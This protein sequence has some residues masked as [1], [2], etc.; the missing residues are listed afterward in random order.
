MTA[1]KST[2]AKRPRKAAKTAEAESPQVPDVGAPEQP[3]QAP[4]PNGAVLTAQQVQQIKQMLGPVLSPHVQYSGDAL[5][6][7]NAVIGNSQKSANTILQI[8]QQ[9]EQAANA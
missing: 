3:G 5:Q 2:P 4:A 6:M 7:A 9:G 8:L 1:K